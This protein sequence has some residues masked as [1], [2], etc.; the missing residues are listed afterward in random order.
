M[1]IRAWNT[2]EQREMYSGRIFTVRR[3][4]LRSPATGRNHDF[5]SW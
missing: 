4:R 5:D 3:D 2:I 1:T